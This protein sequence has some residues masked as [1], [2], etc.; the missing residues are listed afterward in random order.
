MSVA[1]SANNAEIPCGD[2]GCCAIKLRK[3]LRSVMSL[4]VHC[5]PRSATLLRI[6]QKEKELARQREPEPELG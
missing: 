5:G 6:R 2:L 1:V 3:L 4:C